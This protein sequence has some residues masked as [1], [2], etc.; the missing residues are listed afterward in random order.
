VIYTLGQ[1]A[2]AVGKAKSTISRDVKGG[3]ISPTRNPDGSV[4]IDAAELHRVYPA[5][6][7][8][9]TGNGRSNESQPM[10]N[11]SGTVWQREIALL[12]ERLVDKDD[13]IEDLRRRL[14]AEAEE[15]R[16]LTMVLTDLRAGNPATGSRNSE[17][18]DALASKLS[19]G[20]QFDDIE[21]N[22]ADAIGAQRIATSE[23]SALRTELDRRRGWKLLRRLRWALRGDRT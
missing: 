17:S 19:A 3:K 8:T 22:L 10:E 23:A 11:G 9:G 7:A 21:A 14:D 16:K 12:R 2:R 5:M 15:R 13:V 6:P 18:N 20:A 1:A 4:S